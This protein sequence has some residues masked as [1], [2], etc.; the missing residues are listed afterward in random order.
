MLTCMVCPVLEM[1]DRWDH[2][3]QTGQ[4]TEYSLVLLA[5][6]L[7]IVYVLSRFVLK[8]RLP[9]LGKKFVSS[10]RLPKSLLSCGRGCLF[11]VPIDGSPPV[12]ALR[13]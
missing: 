8:L 13:I 6:S 1:F 7:S 12:F 3:L 9:D 4:D 11:D 10:W 2:T 5:L